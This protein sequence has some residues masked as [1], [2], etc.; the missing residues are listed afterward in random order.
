MRA[1]MA[2]F[3][4]PGERFDHPKQQQPNGT[5]DSLETPWKGIPSA[6][7]PL[8]LA[9]TIRLQSLMAYLPC[10]TPT[11]PLNTHVTNGE[12]EGT[13]MEQSLMAC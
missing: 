11:Q 3:C 1:V 7:R 8:E 6:R 10:E 12:I 5:W 13:A 4:T 2:K 9:P